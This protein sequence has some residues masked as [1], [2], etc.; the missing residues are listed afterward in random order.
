MPFQII[1]N[2]AVHASIYYIIGYSFS[3]IFNTSKFFNLF[4][5]G[6]LVLSPYFLYFFSRILFI[7]FVLSILISIAIIVLIA[8]ISNNYVFA[9]LKS[10]SSNNLVL[11]I[12]SL[13]LY[14][15]IES[16][17][18]IFFGSE[19]KILFDPN[20]NNI[21]EISNGF[22]TLINI[23]T[24]LFSIILFVSSSLLMSNSQIGFKV[25]S[26]TNNEELSKIFGINVKRIKNIC[27]AIGSGLVGIAGILISSD[28]GI[29]PTMGFNFLIYG[30]VAMIIGG[31]NSTIGLVGGALLLACA[32][33]FG[34]FYFD[35]KWLDTIAY[36]ILI[37]F[38]IWKPLGF[39]G[40]Q[41]KKVE[42]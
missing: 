34:A 20:P 21:F 30:I 12:S 40:K 26:V 42:I 7:D 37:L 32:Q 15:I 35:S 24:I 38:L 29:T 23:I 9:K 28:I 33:H 39:S 11:L 14:I 19:K 6:I 5:A 8:F 31:I 10:N 18:S 41:L 22:I 1:I 16:L 4:H 17:I 27:F 13:G 25:K 36:I 3:L 2:I